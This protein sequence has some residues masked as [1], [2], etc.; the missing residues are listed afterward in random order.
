MSAAALC[1]AC[2]PATAF[3]EVVELSGISEIDGE[4]LG[5]IE[6]SRGLSDPSEA[7]EP[8]RRRDA[9]AG[10]AVVFDEAIACRLCWLI[11]EV[12]GAARLMLEVEV[13]SAGGELYM[14]VTRGR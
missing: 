6:L 11:V 4:V 10:T 5:M 12:E 1:I 13:I 2:A 14:L 3:A 8:V 9:P 7:L